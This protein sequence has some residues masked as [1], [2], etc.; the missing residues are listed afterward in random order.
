MKVTLKLYRTKEGYK[1][2]K[3]ERQFKLK[4]IVA[5]TEIAK[6]AISVAKATNKE[7]GFKIFRYDQLKQKLPYFKTK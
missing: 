7:I 6:S 5:A 1:D 4:T 2:D 3:P